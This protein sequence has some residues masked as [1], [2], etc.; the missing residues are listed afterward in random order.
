MYDEILNIAEKKNQAEITICNIQKVDERKC[1]TK[2]NAVA[3]FPEKIIL[4]NNISV[5]SDIS[6]FAWTIAFKWII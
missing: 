2:A 5:F 6:Y 4:E 3:W 1:Y